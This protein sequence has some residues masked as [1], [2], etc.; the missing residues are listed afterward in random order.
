MPHNRPL[1]PAL[2][3]LFALAASPAMASGLPDLTARELDVRIHE[4]QNRPLILVYWASWCGPCRH[5][6]QKLQALLDAYQQPRP[7]DVLAVALDTDRRRV[8]NFLAASPLSYPTALAAPDLMA[9]L[10]GA[11]VPTTVLYR[12]DG[13]EARRFVG[14]V[15][16]ER[17]DHFVR[18]LLKQETAASISAP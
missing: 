14:D 2:L 13:A 5:Y 18:T 9:R 17:L 4:R 11:P 7:F 8:E 16:Q 3:L 15:S 12:G 1:L 10:I 6:K